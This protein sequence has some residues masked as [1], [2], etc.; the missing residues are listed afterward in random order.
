MSAVLLGAPGVRVFPKEHG[1]WAMLLVPWAV[2]CGVARTLDGKQILLLVAA[3]S[4]FLAHS[5]LMSWRRLTLIARSDP[6]QRAAA[7]R[8]AIVLGVIGL[9]AAAP[10]LM[11][12]PLG[13]LVLAAGA[14]ILVVASFT[15]ID[16]RADRTLPAQLLAAIGLPVTAPAAYSIAAGFVNRTALALWLLNVTFFLWAVFY[17]RLKIEGRARRTVFPSLASKVAFASDTLGIVAAVLVGLG[18]FSIALGSFSALALLTLVAPAVQTVI[19]VARLERPARL[20]PVGFL[21]AAHATLFGLL[22]IALA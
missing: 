14:G 7:V 12:W 22:A 19:G 17:V 8:L 16:R 9:A 13:F 18:G 4:F 21:M 3:V 20:K 5:Q 6:R 10:L 11:A 15:L 2:G 1:T